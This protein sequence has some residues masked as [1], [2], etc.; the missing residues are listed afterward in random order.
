VDSLLSALIAKRLGFLN[1][2]IRKEFELS[3]HI[4]F[5]ITSFPRLTL[6]F[7]LFMFLINVISGLGLCNDYYTHPET[8]GDYGLSV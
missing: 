4:V 3:T 6:R 8:D 7:K 1:T 2:R 5:I